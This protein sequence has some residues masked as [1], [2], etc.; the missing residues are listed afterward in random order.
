MTG[1]YDY[2]I[3]L[4][5]SENIVNRVKKLKGF[6][7]KKIGEY[8]SLYSKA[9]ITVQYWP[10]KKPLWVEPL[11]PKLE[12][13]LQLLPPVDLTINGFDFFNQHSS[14]TIYA[15][16]RSTALIDV[17]FK[18]LRKYFNTRSFEPH[19]TITKSITDEAFAKLW[20][21][22]KNLAWEEQFIVDKLTILKRAT[23]GYDR[24]YK[25]FKEMHFNQKLDFNAFT[26]AKLKKM[27]FPVTKTGAQQIS[28]F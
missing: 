11:I 2:L 12:R 26:S 15:K 16:L 14:K 17:W 9:H 27:T 18:Q 5:P 6:S 25:V 22:F 24:D 1:Y 8:E 10:R 20:P 21:T 7:L 28:L 19:I 13:E 23:I 3:V 4:S